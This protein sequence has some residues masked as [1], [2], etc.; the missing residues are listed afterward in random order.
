[1]LNELEKKMEKYFRRRRAFEFITKDIKII[2]TATNSDHTAWKLQPLNASS[3]QVDSC[4][5][6]A[7]AMRPFF[8]TEDRFSFEAIVSAL[9]N[10]SI[11][12]DLL[13]RM[14][15]LEEKIVWPK[16]GVLIE[17]K[18]ETTA[19]THNKTF[20]YACLYHS[21]KLSK[22]WNDKLAEIDEK[23]REFYQLYL[24]VSY[25]DYKMRVVREAA[26]HLWIQEKR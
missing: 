12:E 25:L 10:E 1:M 15:E 19:K 24:H 13:K 11:Q 16:E 3:N 4:E 22:N 5:L 2:F 17:A 23:D 26:A 6:F 14:N 9:K 8:L 7:L 18:E 20:E 21:N